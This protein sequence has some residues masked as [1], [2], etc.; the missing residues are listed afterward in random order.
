MAGGDGAGMGGGD[1]DGMAGGDGAGMGGGDVDGMAGG[2]GSGGTGGAEGGLPAGSNV[3]PVVVDQGP[4]AGGGGMFN[5]PYISV[6]ICV[7]GTT[8]CT[9]VD[10]V[11]VDTGST[12]LRLMASALP[13]NFALPA[14]N[15]SDGNPLAECFEFTSSFVWGSVRTADLKIGG[16]TAGNVPFELIGDPAYPNIPTACSSNGGTNENDVMS[17][18]GNGIIGVNQWIY[19]CGDGCNDLYYSCTGTTCSSFAIATADQVPNPVTLFAADNNGVILSFPT[20]PDDGQAT[21]T[22]TLTFGIGTQSNNAIGSATVLTTDANGDIIT[23]A[24]FA[25]QSMPNSYIDSGNTDLV[26]DDSALAICA[27]DP[28]A[29]CPA[30]VTTLM[31]TNQGQNGISS[32]VSFK[33]ASEDS[34]FSNTNTAYDDLAGP[35]GDPTAFEWGFPFFIGRAVYVGF[36]LPSSATPNGYF[37]Y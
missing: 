9:T 26:F 25:T 34:L 21:L 12:G 20:V 31:A 4:P 1:V 14:K 7:P 27:D 35:L 16:E 18:G 28:F 30:A 5:I 24:P 11:S 10:H 17:F 32:S 29:Y 2:D 8:N 15:A 19:D 13:A 6:T 37:A 22:G 3:V 36:A 33:V 23:S